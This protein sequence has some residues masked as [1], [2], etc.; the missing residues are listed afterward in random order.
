M[1]VW[2]VVEA[3]DSTVV[4][5][6]YPCFIR[7]LLRQPAYFVYLSTLTKEHRMA[8]AKSTQPRPLSA[9]AIAR[10]KSGDESADTGENRGL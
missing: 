2:W 7:A 5:P 3:S 4:L 8:A 10:M 1:G 9:V 6:I